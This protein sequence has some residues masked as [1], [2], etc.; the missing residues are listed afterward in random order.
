MFTNFPY[1]TTPSVKDVPTRSRYNTCGA[2]C[3]FWDV[4]LPSC[5]SI[6]GLVLPPPFAGG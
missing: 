3:H 6:T 4:R 5:P 1:I 2:F